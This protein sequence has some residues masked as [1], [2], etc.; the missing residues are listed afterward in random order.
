[1]F[2]VIKYTNTNI[3][4][5]FLK[6]TKQNYKHSITVANM[7]AH[8]LHNVCNYIFSSLCTMFIIKLRTKPANKTF[9]M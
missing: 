6:K 8:I 4:C 1:M 3:F 7:I 5:I 9:F 2:T